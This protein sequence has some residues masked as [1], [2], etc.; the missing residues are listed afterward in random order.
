MAIIDVS[1]QLVKRLKM[2]EEAWRCPLNQHQE[3]QLAEIFQLE[4]LPGRLYK[5]AHKDEAEILTVQ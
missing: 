3:V 2:G 5:Y 1:R 4:V